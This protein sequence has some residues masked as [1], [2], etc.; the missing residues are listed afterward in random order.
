MR[1][2]EGRD[3]GLR[4]FRRACTAQRMTRL[5]RCPR[6][7]AA[8][9]WNDEMD[10]EVDDDTI[11]APTT[12]CDGDGSPRCCVSTLATRLHWVAN[13][14]TDWIDKEPD[15]DVVGRLLNIKTRWRGWVARKMTRSPQ[16]RSAKNI[17]RTFGVLLREWSTTSDTRISRNSLPLLSDFSSWLA[18]T[19]VGHNWNKFTSKSSIISKCYVINQLVNL[20]SAVC[21]FCRYFVSYILCLRF[22]C[23]I[24]YVHV[25]HKSIF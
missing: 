12:A 22:V 7:R 19:R 18:S 23:C 16:G 1:R 10:I 21:Y 13:D 3:T 8:T 20:I 15:F 17:Y 4:W 11:P 24:F 2:L 9:C 5:W 25:F 6:R 14:K